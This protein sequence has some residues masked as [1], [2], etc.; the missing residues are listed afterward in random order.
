MKPLGVLPFACGS[1]RVYVGIEYLE[2]SIVSF[3][4]RTFLQCVFRMSGSRQCVEALGF[5][6][7]SCPF[8]AVSCPESKLGLLG[9]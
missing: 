9:F 3:L 8:G 2:L 1:F 5:G 6:A 4:G 7:V